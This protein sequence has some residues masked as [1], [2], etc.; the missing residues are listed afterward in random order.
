MGIFSG[1]FSTGSSTVRRGNAESFRG[2]L[3]GS[4]VLMQEEILLRMPSLKTVPVSVPWLS[5][6][7]SSWEERKTTALAQH[8]QSTRTPPGFTPALPKSTEPYNTSSSGLISRNF[9][10]PKMSTVE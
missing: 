10:S 9:E 5:K 8:H 4:L 2:F 3:P 6:V 7:P 1:P